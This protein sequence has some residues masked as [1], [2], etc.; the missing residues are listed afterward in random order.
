MEPQPSAVYLDQY[1]LIT[2]FIYHHNWKWTAESSQPINGD[3]IYDLTRD[4]RHLVVFRDKTHWNIDGDDPQVLDTLAK[5]LR[6]GKAPEL[7][8]FSVRQSPPRPPISNVRALKF[9]LSRAAAD[10]RICAE[11]MSVNAT[12]WFVTFRNSRCPTLDESIRTTGDFDD[13][14]DSIEYVGAW[15]QV[16]VSD[17]RNGTVSYSRDA[18]SVARLEFEGTQITYGYTKAFNR[19]IAEIRIDGINKGTIDLFDK[20]IGWQSVRTWEAL[21]AGRHTFELLVTGQ[22]NS[23]SKDQ[24]VDLDWLSAK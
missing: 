6:T 21:P 2:F 17:A 22:R 10:R 19:G 8:V 7:S 9:A 15:T 13:V 12:Q 14:D 4:G 18:G 23:Q 20:Q 1:N 3:D 24:F 5:A 11:R 16:G